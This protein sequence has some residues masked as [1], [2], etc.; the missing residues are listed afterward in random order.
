MQT[1]SALAAKLPKHQQSSGSTLT[2]TAHSKRS[3]KLT[4]PGFL[5]VFVTLFLALGAINGQNNLLFWLFGFSIAALIVSGIITGTALVNIKLAAHP[6]QISELGSTLKA[7]YTL[8]N[9]SKLLPNFALEII[10]L[11]HPHAHSAPGVVLHLRPNAEAT[12]HANLT[13]QVRG[14]LA[15]NTIRV[16]TRFPFGLFTKSVDFQFHRQTLV[17]PKPMDTAQL[18]WNNQN[19]NAESETRSLNRRGSGLDYFA[20][21]QYQPGD[22][23]RRIAWKQSARTDSLLVTEYP[24]TASIQRTIELAEPTSQTPDELFE[25]AISIAYTLIK[26]APPNARISLSIPWDGTVIPP[27]T[28]RAH[29]DRCAKALAMLTRPITPTASNPTSARNQQPIIIGY[30]RSADLYPSSIYA[31]DFISDTP[32]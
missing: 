27:M 24:E 28:G 23:L 9:P 6:L 5:F 25:L 4:A 17:L 3:S 26:E 16:R 21:R 13:P 10:E 12:G 22:P 15:L 1:P 14:Q 32:Q 31:E 8:Y 18:D 19:T 29:T 2:A 7:S 11:D 20:L 30:T